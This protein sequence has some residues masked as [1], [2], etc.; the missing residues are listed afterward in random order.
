MARI[1]RLD[2]HRVPASTAVP[3]CFVRVTNPDHKG[4]VEFQFSIGDPK[5]YLEMTLPPAAFDEFCRQHGATHL[6][7][8][9]ARAVD[10]FENTWRYG[11]EDEDDHDD[12]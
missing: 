12:D 9:Q 6:S 4:F 10:E 5:L 2:A 8:A 7:A 11:R 3:A 1:T